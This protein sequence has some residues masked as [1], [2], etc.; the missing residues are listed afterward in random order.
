MPRFAA[1]LTMMFP[2]V[3]FLDRFEAAAGVGFEAVEFLFPYDFS[4]DVLKEKLDCFGLEQVLINAPAGAWDA[5]ERGLA[6]LPGAGV[7]FAESIRVALEYAKTLDC[8]RI[9]VMAGIAAGSDERG[10][11]FERYVER[12]RYAADEAARA[13]RGVTIEPLNPRDMPGY[14]LTSVH[15]AVEVLAAVDRPNAGLQ[16]DFYHA[17]IVHGDLTILL[18]EVIEHVT[19]VQIAAVPNRDEP[20]RGEVS[21]AHVLGELDALGYRGWV[22]CEY[23]PA[24]A[25]VAGLTWMDPYRE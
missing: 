15:D 2:E 23:V 8:P 6:A 19:H 20:D 17:Q 9:H 16:L 10:E 1:N 25:T 4:P 7:R 13:G 18:R 12:I 3:E 21:F 22:G 11:Q 24:G 5:G 14:F